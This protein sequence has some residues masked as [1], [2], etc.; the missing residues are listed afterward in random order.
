MT[1]LDFMVRIF[2]GE[3]GNSL[4]GSLIV[5]TERYLEFNISSVSTISVS[6]DSWSKVF[7]MSL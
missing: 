7:T 3:S 6:K 4:V 5:S 2:A 1:I